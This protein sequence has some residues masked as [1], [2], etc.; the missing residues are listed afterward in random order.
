MPVLALSAHTVARSPSFAT[1]IARL[2]SEVVAAA[3]AGAAT[4]V[5]PEYAALELS[6]LLDGVDAN[7]IAGEIAGIQQFHD[8]WVATHEAWA[9]HYNMHIVAGSFPLVC[10]D[11]KTRNRAWLLGPNGVLGYQDKIMMTRFESEQ[12][13]ITGGDGG[14]KVWDLGWCKAAIAI[15]YDIEFPVLVRQAA[16]AGAELLIVPSNTDGWHG[17]WRVR[18]GAQARA[19]E[20]QCFAAMAP[21]T[22]LADWTES[23]DVNVGRAGVFGPVDSGFPSDGILALGEESGGLLCCPLSPRRIHSVRRHGQNRNFSDWENS[24]R[25]HTAP[26]P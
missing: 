5:F 14:L 1:L 7:D 11:G 6:C 12:W 25:T 4:L 18:I 22:G 13:F 26:L 15:C 2:E 20:N 24:L 17:Y 9:K 8:A 3:A 23:I 19:L 21:L 16:A 10:Q